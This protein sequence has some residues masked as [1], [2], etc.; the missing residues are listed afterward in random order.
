MALLD[1]R[2]SQNVAG[3]FF[4]DSTCID[5]DTCRQLAPHAFARSAAIEKLFVYRQPSGGEA[6]TR[7]L[8]ALVACPTN[9]IGTVP[10]IDAKHA[11]RLFPEHIEEGV[12]YCGFTAESSFGASSYLIVRP[13][14]NVL[15]DSPR[16]AGPLLRRIEELGGVERMFLS[17]RDD[18]ADHARFR[19]HFGCERVVHRQEHIEAETL[20]DGA[21]PIPL[22][23]DLIAIPVPGHTRGSTALLYRDK[24]LFTGDHL[25]ESEEDESLEASRSVCWYSWPDQLRSLE[26]LLDFDFQW[27]L[28]GHG[29]RYHASSAAAMREELKG[30]LLRLGKSRGR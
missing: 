14:G 27:V 11:A 20:L 13:E 8:M 16:S 19:R 2:L 1:L 29:R 9:S 5:C 18:V 7:A 22:A 6:Q 15:V 12:F 21:S 28:P 17:H 25:W 10:K 30:L 24:F 26:R 23:P 4:V 3:D